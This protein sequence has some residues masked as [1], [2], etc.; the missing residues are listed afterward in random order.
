MLAP[1][2]MASR[3]QALAPVF[4]VSPSLSSMPDRAARS[5]VAEITRTS[6]SNESIVPIAAN[7]GCAHR[8]SSASRAILATVSDL[9][10]GYPHQS[11]AR[12]AVDVDLRAGRNVMDCGGT[13]SAPALQC[14]R[15]MTP[16]RGF[17]PQQR[18]ANLPR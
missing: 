18:L 4:T 10:I 14:A 5:A 13:G 3:A 2:I 11:N 12:A 16:P 15:P 7:S 8:H 1:S 9:V 6:P 17:D